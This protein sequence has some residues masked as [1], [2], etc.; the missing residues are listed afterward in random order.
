MPEK[1]RC[2]KQSLCG[3][4]KLYSFSVVGNLVRQSS[5][6]SKR[7]TFQAN[8][9]SVKKI[10]ILTGEEDESVSFKSL[11]ETETL[12]SPAYTESSSVGSF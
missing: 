12:P 7:Y 3:K 11:R 6:S 1:A 10:N 5:I 2:L 9:N 4:K 8:S